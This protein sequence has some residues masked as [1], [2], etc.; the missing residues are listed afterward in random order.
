MIVADNS[1]TMEKDNPTVFGQTDDKLIYD[2][3]VY[4]Y[5]QVF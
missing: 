4:L 3:N 5:L 1:D 2:V